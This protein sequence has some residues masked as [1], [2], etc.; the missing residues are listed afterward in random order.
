MSSKKST[1]NGWPFVF[2]LTFFFSSV[3]CSPAHAQSSDCILSMQPQT[4]TLNVGA[5]GASPISVSA[6][7]D[8]TWEFSGLPDWVFITEVVLE[9]GTQLDLQGKQHGPITVTGSATIYLYVP[10]DPKRQKRACSCKCGGRKLVIVDD[11][12]PAIYPRTNSED[13]DASG[14]D[15]YCCLFRIPHSHNPNNC[16]IH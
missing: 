1:W 10:A 7:A 13:G 3:I 11:R 8:C 9:D 14:G 4:L 5:N 6:P 12:Y 15:D 2:A 16:P